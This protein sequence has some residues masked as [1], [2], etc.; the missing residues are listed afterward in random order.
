MTLEFGGGR[1]LDDF[2]LN[3]SNIWPPNFKSGFDLRIFEWNKKKSILK[4]PN[5]L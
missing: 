2:S 1:I 3:K 4:L 5:L